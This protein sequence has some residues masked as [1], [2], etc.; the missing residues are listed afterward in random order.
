MPVVVGTS[1]WQYR[2]W[3]GPLYP[4]DL[5][6]HDWLAHYAGRYAAVENNSTFY[7]LPTRDTFADWQART[8]ADFVMAIKASRYLTH[9]KRLRDPADA[10]AKL[11]AAA[12]GLGG[13]L[14]PVLLQLPPNLPA[15]P[16]RLDACLAAFAGRRADGPDGVRVAVEPRHPSWWT[17]EVR[18]V[19]AARG[20][21]LCWADQLGRP[22]TPLWRTAELG[23]SP[24]PPGGGAALAALR[25]A[26]A[27]LLGGAAGR[28]AGR[29]DRVRVLQQRPRRRGPRRLGRL[30]GR[31]PPGRAHGHP[32]A[33]VTGTTC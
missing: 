17:D 28:L 11:M 9:V 32:G 2:D 20:A 23:L 7:R 21:A 5:P 6:Q 15:D 8:P 27:A 3:R 25:A 26:R 29:G 14:G 1:G 4:P 16:Q 10:V 24:L 19:L 18:Q 12:S 22:V 31:L 13:R 33:R 30:R